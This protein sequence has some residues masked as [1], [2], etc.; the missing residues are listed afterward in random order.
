[1]IAEATALA[2]KDA[3]NDAQS[4]LRRVVEVWRQRSIWDPNVQADVEARVE[5]RNIKLQAV[6]CSDTT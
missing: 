2:F 5:G 3:T 6:S 1:M 4:K